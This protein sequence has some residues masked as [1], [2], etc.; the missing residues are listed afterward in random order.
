MVSDVDQCREDLLRIW[1][2]VS[3]GSSFTFRIASCV[4]RICSSYRHGIWRNPHSES[5]PVWRGSSPPRHSIWRHP[6]S[7]SIPYVQD[8]LRMVS[9]VINTQNKVLFQL[10]RDVF[11]ECSSQTFLKLCSFYCTSCFLSQQ[12]HLLAMLIDSGI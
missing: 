3:V 7:E 5:I 12:F 1:S 4:G 8:L 9:V 11:F 6:H 2:L 10:T